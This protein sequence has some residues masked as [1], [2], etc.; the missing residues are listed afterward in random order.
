MSENTNPTI[1]SMVPAEQQGKLLW[2]VIHTYS[3]YENK[4]LS[5]LQKAVDKSEAMSKLIHEICIPMEEVEEIRNGRRVKVQ[6][7]IFPGY[8]M[9]HMIWTADSWYLV[10][11]TRGVTGFVG[12][13][14]KPVALSEEEVERM[15]HPASTEIKTDIAIGQDVRVLSGSLENVIATVEDIDPMLGTV[16]VKVMMFAGREQLVDLPIDQVQK[17]EN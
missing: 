16:K 14:S 2:Y 15:L 8:V 12:P 1:D 11:N 17:V 6:R 4:V 7:K 13:E 3:G 9:V 10:R 5:T